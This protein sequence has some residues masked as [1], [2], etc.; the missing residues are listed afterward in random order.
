MVESVK[1]AL[2]LEVHRNWVVA[3]EKELN[4]TRSNYIKGLKIIDFGEGN[5][6]I[7][8]VGRFNNMLENGVTAFDMKCITNRNTL[9]YTSKGN[10]K[11]CDIK[12]GDLV[13]THSGKFKRVSGLFKEL[14]DDRFVYKI[15]PIYSNRDQT[16]SLY[17]TGNHPILTN[18]GWVKAENLIEDKHKLFTIANKC[19]CGKRISRMFTD[20]F[21]QKRYC[22]KSCSATG[23]N[24]SRKDN[25]K[26]YLKPETCE[27]LRNAVIE[28]NKKSIE[29]GTH[30][31]QTGLLNNWIQNNAKNNSDWGF[32]T[33]DDEKGKELQYK[34]AVSLGKKNKFTDPES[35]L[36]N[37]INN[38]EG[39]ERQFQFERNVRCEAMNRNRFYY[40]DFA[41]PKHKI[42]IEVNGEYWH[43]KEQDETKKSEVEAAGWRYISF[44]SKEVYS[45]LNECK[46][47]IERVLDNHNDN[48][49]FL[50]HN[51]EIEKI[52]IT[53][54]SSR[55]HYYKYN[56]T[57]EDDSS[58]IAA[59]IVTHNSGFAKSSKVKMSK[60][61][62]WYISI[63]FRWAT[64][65]AIGE[66]EIFSG[67][68][69]PEIYAILKT[70]GNNEGIGFKDL[71]VE[72][73]Q[74]KTRAE[75]SN[76]LGKT[77]DAYV[78]KSSIYEGI[79][80][81]LKTF[82]SG[83]QQST[84]NSFRTVSA[85]SDPSSWIHKGI[86]MHNLAQQAIDNTDDDTIVNNVVDRSLSEFVF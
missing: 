43:T 37:V 30:V 73:L 80:R 14:N 15:T 16:K 76:N 64:T 71:A 33:I 81:S 24:L 60:K 56:L 7:Q 40:F 70:K 26:P 9:I 59:G 86:K 51:F 47:E 6:G 13:L 5:A 66:N 41:I 27:K 53:N 77:F 3:A 39:I 20:K 45:K 75:T 84:Y 10:V 49:S 32:G 21:E 48:Y 78:H 69:P 8:L 1:Q 44:W 82:P 61:G 36:W 74:K 18:A 57:V 19:V 58:Y 85:L 29:N 34:A 55:A 67:V 31:T 12:V 79:V 62:N 83:A 4:S 72:F 22:S 68:L 35:V 63:P 25:G 54:D 50:Q 17:V 2:A 23:S 46:N 65:G 38:I 42:C 52:D 11:I 28:L